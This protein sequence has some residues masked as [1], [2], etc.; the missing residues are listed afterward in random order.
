MVSQLY[1]LLGVKTAEVHQQPANNATARPFL[2]AAE[3]KGGITGNV[4]IYCFVSMSEQVRKYIGQHVKFRGHIYIASV[5]KCYFFTRSNKV[6][7]DSRQRC[8]A[9]LNF[10]NRYFTFS[11]KTTIGTG[12]ANEF[13]SYHFIK[14]FIAFVRCSPSKPERCFLPLWAN[15]P[16]DTRGQPTRLGEP[17]QANRREY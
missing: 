14:L 9:R 11:E 4:L 10:P 1:H 2:K 12:P 3:E 16:I 6:D 17:K 8:T 5:G 15:L 13:I 7:V